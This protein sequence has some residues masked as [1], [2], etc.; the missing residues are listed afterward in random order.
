MSQLVPGACVAELQH[1]LNVKEEE[2]GRLSAQQVSGDVPLQ[3]SCL[4]EG[5]RGKEAMTEA[6]PSKNA[7]DRSWSP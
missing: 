5:I 4:E 7:E 1:L 3:A 2:A 6:M